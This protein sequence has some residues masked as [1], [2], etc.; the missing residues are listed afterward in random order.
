MFLR[1]LMSDLPGLGPEERFVLA[2]FLMQFGDAGPVQLTVRDLAER[3]SVSPQQWMRTADRLRKGGF[4]LTKVVPQGRGRPSRSY[5]ISPSLILSKEVADCAL[6]NK[7]IIRCLLS[8]RNIFES[9][10]GGSISAKQVGE[11]AGY[12][13]PPARGGDG[14]LSVSNRLL[15]AVLVLHANKLG[16]VRDVGMLKLRKMTGIDEVNLKPR[17]HRLALMGF[18]RRIVPG[19]SRSIFVRSKVSTTYFLNFNHPQL[20][21]AAVTAVLAIYERS[22]YRKEAL[23]NAAP[24]AVLNFLE[25]VKDEAFDILCLRLSEHTAYMLGEHWHELGR[26]QQSELQQLLLHRLSADFRRPIGDAADGL[27]ISQSDWCTV[28]DHFCWLVFGRAEKIKS[29]LRYWITAEITISKAELVPSPYSNGV[30]ATTILLEYSALPSVRYL[31]IWDIYEGFCIP[32]NEEPDMPVEIRC[33]LGL[34][35]DPLQGRTKLRFF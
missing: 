15:L 7:K 18:I 28:L 30:Q 10:S 3:L 35:T 13:T 16:A 31:V 9:E 6:V 11:R 27:E 21:P 24:S 8:C 22:G 32:Y 33:E 26:T 29:R 34:L 20:L 19:V 25:Y 2:A 4:L 5:E 1:V 17:L 14:R 12:K 23:T